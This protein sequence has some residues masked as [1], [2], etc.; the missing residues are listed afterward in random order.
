MVFYS[1][2]HPLSDVELCEEIKKL[3][4]NMCWVILM[5]SGGHFAGAVFDG[6]EMQ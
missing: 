2:D 4:V 1:Q 5:A 6:Y 3:S